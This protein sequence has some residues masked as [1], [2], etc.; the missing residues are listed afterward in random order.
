MN[1]LWLLVE[2]CMKRRWLMAALAASRVGRCWAAWARHKGEC[3]GASCCIS[4]CSMQAIERD[5][6]LCNRGL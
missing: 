2:V 5:F 6:L 1:L 4:S 3:E